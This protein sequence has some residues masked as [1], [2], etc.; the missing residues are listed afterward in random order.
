M[1][2]LFLILLLCLITTSALGQFQQRPMLGEQI[3]RTYQLGD[4]VV[5]WLFNEGSGNKVYDLSGNGNH[6]T[7]DGTA[8]SWIPGK[9]GPSVNLPGT[10]EYISTDIQIVSGTPVTMMAW[11]RPNA[12][13]QTSRLMGLYV[14]G[15]TRVIGVFLDGVDNEIIAQHYDGSNAITRSITHYAANEWMHC[16]AV[17]ESD[18]KRAI[19]ING[20]WESEN[21]TIQGSIGIIDKFTIGRNEFATPG[22]WINSQIDHVII[23]NRALSPSEVAELYREPF[24]MFAEDNIIA[25]MAVEAPAPSGG[26]V[27]MITS[28]PVIF[29]GLY[30]WKYK[31]A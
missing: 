8:P 25:L 23:Y 16:T 6:G 31:E 19:Y 1:R 27:I 17:F 22:E 18:S 13:G 30:L 9:F 15:Q 5:F 12:I 7:V 21:P 3:D 2:K 28:L 29:I 4:P 14:S 11:F 24:C 10:D 20:I 26:Q